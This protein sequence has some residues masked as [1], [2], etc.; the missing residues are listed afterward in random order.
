[1]SLANELNKAFGSIMKTRNEQAQLFSTGYPPLN[2]VVSGRYQGGL[3][4]GR[5]AEVVGAS[6]TGKTLIAVEVAKSVQKA[7]GVALYMDHERRFNVDFASSLGL[8][9]E[10]PYFTWLPGRSW[11]DS[12]VATIRFGKMVRESG[13]FDQETPI[14]VIIDSVA[15]AVPR[16]K[17]ETDKLENL[18]YSM[19][20]NLA[21]AK[22]VS[23]TMPAIAQHCDDLNITLL[24]L[25]QVRENP[26]VVYGN[27]T[28]SP[29]GKAISFY[30]DVRLELSRSMDK[31]GKDVIGQTVNCRC[32]KGLTAPGK[33][34]SWV[35]RFLD[36]GMTVFD[37]EASLVEHAIEVG[38][39][40][41]P[42][43]GF[44]T[45]NGA[46]LRKK[47]IIEDVRDNGRLQEVSDLLKDH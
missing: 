22:A 26:G 46:K 5:I 38:A 41:S 42:S 15:A 37:I 33:K 1:M 18:E 36:N 32:H 7:G 40:E 14:L 30:A 4:S 29:G 39:I 25:N 10:S 8:N 28:T 9:T 11:E 24:L 31:E 45:W 27:P 21:L 47:Q 19:A 23:S 44:Y 13:E 3:P 17:L 6:Q 43:K 35:L 20:D 2:K 34:T 16:S 12:C